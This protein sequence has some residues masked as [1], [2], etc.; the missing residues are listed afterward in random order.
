MF[1]Y[2]EDGFGDLE[3]EG[4]VLVIGGEFND[5]FCFEGCFGS[6][7]VDD[8]V[9]GV[10]LVIDNYIGFYVKGGMWFVDMVFFYV[11]F[12]YLLVDFKFYD[13]NYYDMELDLF[14]GVGVDVNF[15]DF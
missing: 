3:L 14:Y 2:S 8:N 10:V 13:V 15:G 9:V 11:I 4:V 12:G 6:S 5:N 7:I 1:I